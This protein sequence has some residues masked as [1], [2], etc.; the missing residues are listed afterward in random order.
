MRFLQTVGGSVSYAEQTNAQVNPLLETEAREIVGVLVHGLAI[1]NLVASSA[2][3]LQRHNA[4]ASK[5]TPDDQSRSGLDPLP[6]SERVL[7]H[8]RHVEVV[9]NC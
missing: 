7:G 2:R 8:R 9:L 1:E 4:L 6:V 5:H 3:E